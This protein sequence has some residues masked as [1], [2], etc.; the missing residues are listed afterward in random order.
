MVSQSPNHM[1]PCRRLIRPCRHVLPKS[2]LSAA[3]RESPLFQTALVNR[4]DDV[5]SV[6]S[7]IDKCT[8]LTRLLQT[9]E[10]TSKPAMLLLRRFSDERSSLDHA[11]GCKWYELQ[12]GDPA[13]DPQTP[14]DYLLCLAALAYTF[15]HLRKFIQGPWIQD[16]VDKLTARLPTTTFFVTEIELAHFAALLWV[17]MVAVKFCEQ[18]RTLEHAREFLRGIMLRTGTTTVERADNCLVGLPWN[19]TL[20]DTRLT[21]VV[22]E[23]TRASAHAA[24]ATEWTALSPPS[25]S[26]NTIHE[27]LA[28]REHPANSEWVLS[29]LEVP[30]SAGSSRRKR[31]RDFGREIA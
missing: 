8:E 31:E 6:R 14:L 10:S 16:V 11:L 4:V 29:S 24:S 12:H 25:A 20:W 3:Y 13:G 15:C 9:I 1:K 28:I 19:R 21:E 27:A 22:E 2:V 30:V 18:P 5:P 7:L 17:A 23:V 26:P